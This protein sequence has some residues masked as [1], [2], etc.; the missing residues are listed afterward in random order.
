MRFVPLKSV[1]QQD[2]Q[3]PHRTRRLVTKQRTKV[4]AINCVGCWPSMG[5]RY[6]GGLR[7]CGARPSSWRPSPAVS[8]AP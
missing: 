2:I 8:M 6:A 3:S 5:S 1:A 7:R 4:C